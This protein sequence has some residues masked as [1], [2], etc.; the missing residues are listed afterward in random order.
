VHLAILF[1]DVIRHSGAKDFADVARLAGLCRERI[2]QV[3]RLTY[4]ASDIQDARAVERGDVQG[5]GGVD[6]IDDEGPV[7]GLA[8]W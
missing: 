2:S 5:D 6:A 3:M 8:V 7:F 1:D 4:L